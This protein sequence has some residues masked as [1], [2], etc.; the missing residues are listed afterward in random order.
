MFLERVVLAFTSF[1]LH[2][3]STSHVSLKVTVAMI[4]F[5]SILKKYRSAVGPLVLKERWCVKVKRTT[6]T[7]SLNESYH[8]GSSGLLVSMSVLA[9]L[10]PAKASL[11]FSLFGILC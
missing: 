9:A 10:P 2:F 7:G 5:H 11:G 8:E 6:Q 1:A 3:C 4:E